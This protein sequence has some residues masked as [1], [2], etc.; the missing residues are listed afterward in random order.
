MRIGDTLV[1]PD[2]TRCGVAGVT[3]ERILEMAS[4]LGYDAA[5]RHVRLSELMDADEVIVCNSLFGA[6]QVRQLASHSWPL[7][8]LASRLRNKLHLD[9]ANNN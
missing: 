3:R 7:G 5:V 8:A 9:D 6:W 2:L 4:E 1:T